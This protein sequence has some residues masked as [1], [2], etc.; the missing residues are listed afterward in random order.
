MEFEFENLDLNKE[1]LKDLIYEEIML[2]HFPD[3]KQ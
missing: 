3:F 1:Q 2:Y